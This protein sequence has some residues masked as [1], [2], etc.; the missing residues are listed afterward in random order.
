MNS[1]ADHFT[2]TAQKHINLVPT[3][4]TLTFTMNNFTFHCEPDRWIKSN[5]RLFMDQLL[6]RKMAADPA[7]SHHQ[8]MAMWLYQSPNPPS[9]VYHR[10]MS[11]YTAA[12]QLYIRSGQLATAEKVEEWQGEGNGGMCRLDCHK[13]EDE[14]HIFV[15][16]PVFNEWREQAGQHLSG[17]VEGRLDKADITACYK[18]RILTKA[19]SFYSDDPKLWLLKTSQFYLGHVPKI[20]DWTPQD[21]DDS[22]LLSKRTVDTWHILQLAQC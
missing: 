5:I 17:E 4:P 6:S 16:C 3:A 13:I 19:K 11:A 12:I 7:L 8:R 20:S 1:D 2:T 9:Y 22:N 21:H 10:A 14:H 18:N 15:K